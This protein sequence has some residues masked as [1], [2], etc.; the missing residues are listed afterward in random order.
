MSMF[1]NKTKPE[2]E[3]GNFIAYADEPNTIVSGSG[4]GAVYLEAEYIVESETYTPKFSYNDVK[5][6]V[7]AGKIVFIR[8]AYSNDSGADLIE[9]HPVNTVATYSDPVEYA[10]FAD[11]LRFTA[12][13]PDAQMTYN[14]E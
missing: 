3:S 5:N 13:D 7:E 2:L 12:D 6:A 1:E 14:D 11:R 4:G 9:T 10:V 8:S